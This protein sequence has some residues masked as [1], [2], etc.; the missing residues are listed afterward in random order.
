M[1]ND[2]ID[3]SNV[4]ISIHNKQ[5]NNTVEFNNKEI[6]KYKNS[7]SK[8]NNKDNTVDNN[9]SIAEQMSKAL[10]ENNNYNKDK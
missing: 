9:T 7:K 3:S 1:A 6:F 4:S 2:F 8:T 5:I 10:R